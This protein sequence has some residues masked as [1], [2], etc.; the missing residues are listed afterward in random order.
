MTVKPEL[1]VE[2]LH[3]KIDLVQL[4]RDEPGE[5]VQEGQVEVLKF[6]VSLVFDETQLDAWK[7]K[8]NGIRSNIFPS[9]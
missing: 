7:R 8:K 9:A 1:L 3:K 4:V 2:Q 5:V 6:R